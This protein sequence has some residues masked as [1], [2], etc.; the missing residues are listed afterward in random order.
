MQQRDNL[1]ER[2][3]SGKESLRSRKRK[4][5]CF[6]MAVMVAL[7]SLG[8]AVALAK[9]V[10]LTSEQR[11]KDGLMLKHVNNNTV[12]FPGDT[13]LYTSDA[14][15]HPLQKI[16]YYD[17][18]GTRLGNEIIPDSSNKY[19]IETYE[20]M[21]AGKASPSP[22]PAAFGGW[23]IWYE[24]KDM[25]DKYSVLWGSDNDSGNLKILR[26]YAVDTNDYY[27]VHFDPRGAVNENGDPIEIDDQLVK[28]DPLYYDEYQDPHY[29]RVFEPEIK[30]KDHELIGWFKWE[31]NRYGDE[32]YFDG[33]PFGGE[34]TLAAKWR[35]P[36]RYYENHNGVK[37]GTDENPET[38]YG[39]EQVNCD[40]LPECRLK[41]KLPD[42]GLDPRDVV[43]QIPVWDGHTF[44]G[45][46]DEYGYM[47]FEKDGAGVS[48]TDDARPM[49]D[50][51]DLFAA[52]SGYKV[53]FDPNGGTLADGSTTPKKVELTTTAF[54]DR[55]A[56]PSHSKFEFD[57]NWY[58]D[59]ELTTPFNFYA[60][61]EKDITLY[62]GW[63]CT[64]TFDGNGGNCGG[65][66]KR[67]LV[68]HP[69]EIIN[70]PSDA[71]IIF[72]RE[73]YTL[74]GWKDDKTG[75]K[76][77][78]GKTTINE[79]KTL[80]AEWKLSNYTVKFDPNGGSGTMADQERGYNDKK[81]LTANAF[82]RNG[83][84][85]SSWNTKADGSGEKYDD[86]AVVELCDLADENGGTVT[87]YAQWGTG[88][89][90]KV[91]PFDTTG[92]L[93]QVVIYDRDESSITISWNKIP[94]ADG[95]FV[96]FKKCHTFPL[97]KIADITD[98]NTLSFTKTGL[99]KGTYYKFKLKAYKK[100]G[101]KKKVIRKSLI[102]HGVTVGSSKYTIAK[103]VKITGAKG[104]DLIPLSGNSAVS[105]NSA[106]P[107]YSLKLNK[108]TK[109]GR[110]AKIK[111]EEVPEEEGKKIEKH[112]GSSKKNPNI[113]Y[114]SNDPSVATVTLK[115]KIKAKGSGKC[116]IF[117]VSQSGMLN[118]IQVTVE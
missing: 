113:H 72:T 103:D 118:A 90:G 8:P 27:R 112:R 62:A 94:D 9:T 7:S 57:G 81:P 14:N 116:T 60:P 70:D 64:L 40:A 53:T 32:Y 6:M 115:G 38:P 12:L 10:D 95:Y 24:Y 54:V 33:D 109:K 66:E 74:A 91:I 4:F 17:A 77:E 25:S 51:L 111:A 34:T 86:K 73:G 42:G 80:V 41:N 19:K 63:N 105:G 110:K 26:L 102:A 43:P 48:I 83:Y 36:V 1:R 35:Y 16:E 88:S 114:Q 30:W 96:Y 106:E 98:I 76:P 28:D 78:F 44:L 97:K 89:S 82:T 93:L 2:I 29:V 31:N 37:R 85:F 20:T 49:R 104:A 18:A 92:R 15:D 71:E 3:I 23:R 117:A 13:I 21:I 75:E 59:K 39:Y 22:V 65:D 108:S 84:S 87:L 55:P 46:Y 5:L 61:V 56:D 47:W 52:W 69:G 58:T 100:V 45:W 50:D 79:N 107:P 11:A 67:P 99:K 68:L 101:N